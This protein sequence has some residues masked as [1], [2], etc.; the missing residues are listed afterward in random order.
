[1]KA[2]MRIVS[3]ALTLLIGAALFFALQRTLEHHVKSDWIELVKEKDSGKYSFSLDVATSDLPIPPIQSLGG[4]AKFIGQGSSS[5][6]RL[7]YKILA[8][9]G[10]LDRSKIPS[11]YLRSKPVDLGDGKTITQLPI[12]QSNHEAH[13]TFVL[14]DK[15]GFKLLELRSE[16]HDL[17]SNKSN[18]FQGMATPVVD[19]SVASRTQEITYSLSI[20]KCITCE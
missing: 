2:L 10:D 4:R 20:D 19:K 15:D 8:V 13:F 18:T 7:G 9:T 6:V 11:K 3:Y 5:N 1:M 14:K 16:Q 12:R 17:Q